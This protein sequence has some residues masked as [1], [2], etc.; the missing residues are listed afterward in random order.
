MQSSGLPVEGV[1]IAAVTQLFTEPYMVQFLLQN[2]L[3]A[4]WINLHPESPLEKKWAYHKSHVEH[5]FSAW[6]KSA[7]EVKIIDPCR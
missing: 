1:D 4:W 7:S 3:G 5:D 6:P 2:T